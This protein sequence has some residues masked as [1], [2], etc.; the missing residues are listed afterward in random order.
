MKPEEF[1]LEIKR[2]VYIVTFFFTVRVLNIK[3]QTMVP[4][5]K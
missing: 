4:S 5:I 2:P 1:L 3:S